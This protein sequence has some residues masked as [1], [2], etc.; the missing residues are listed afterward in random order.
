MKSMKFIGMPQMQDVYSIDAFYKKL[1]DQAPGIVYKIVCTEPGVCSIVYV[2]ENVNEV[3]ELTVDQLRLDPD[4]FFNERIE[5]TDSDGFID[6]LQHAIENLTDWNHTY[7]VR[8]PKKGLRWM[9]GTGKPE[10]L[11]NG[12][13][14]VC[15]TVIDITDGKEQEERL[16]LS[17]ERLT[18]AMQAAGEG[19]WDWDMVTNKVY[20]SAQL[21]KIL[22][23]EEKEDFFSREF[24]LSRI[25]PDDLKVYEKA[26]QK[27]LEKK[28]TA[29]YESIYRIYTEQ[30][31]YRWV[32][33]RGRV[34]SY[35]ENNTPLR[36]IGT[37][38]DVT[39]LK[40]KEIQLSNTM[41]IIGDQNKRLS[42]FAHIVSH[43]L[44]SHAGNLKMFL[45]IFKTAS[46]DEREEMLEHL[47]GI[48]N[49]LTI[50]I[51]HLKEL[52]EI[53]A[54]IKN[55]REKLNLRHYLKNI[56]SILHNE[57]TK[58]GVNI[59]INIPLD[60]TVEYNPAYLESVLL[61]LTTNAIKY[62]ATGRNP[63]LSYDFEI[64]NGQKILGVTDNGL[65]IDL[66][67]HGKDLFGMYK[68][69]HK[70]QNSR[71]IGLFITK[72]QVEAMGGKIEVESEVNKGTTFKIYFDDEN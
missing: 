3:Y 24:W 31:V 48:T 37:L 14:E 33:S 47:E 70:H 57:I 45:D 30:G 40:D 29:N 18:F 54:E 43:N 7:R 69:F 13:I 12:H 46:N 63:I 56:L 50:T 52:V 23:F 19:V 62:S 26:K 41:N 35:D 25:H 36:A 38:K 22:G 59:E 55:V 39:M 42:N 5:E 21:M 1:L 28:A 60:V 20:F 51:Q 8:L 68:T 4:V 67:K 34:I 6:T 65:G 71:G 72:N 9:R 16:L 44:R 53:Q 61:N 32:L 2:S 27:H 15:G 49:G 58:H 17:E 66:K 10:L 11:P 64:V